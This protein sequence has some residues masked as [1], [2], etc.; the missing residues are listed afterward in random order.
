MTTATPDLDDYIQFFAAM[1]EICAA[2]WHSGVRF[3]V[4]RDQSRV[5]VTIATDEAEFSL[6]W[7]RNGIRTLG[8][9]LVMVA[10][11]TLDR[12]VLV[13]KTATDRPIVCIVRM[14]PQIQ[15]ELDMSW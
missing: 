7:E 13:I 5:V 12:D 1:P 9:R 6:Q 11:W 15:V 8:L 3:D 4:I 10:S 2:D 14:E